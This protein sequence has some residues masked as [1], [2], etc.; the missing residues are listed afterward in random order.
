[1]RKRHPGNVFN[2]LESRLVEFFRFVEERC[3]STMIPHVEFYIFEVTMH[4]F[5]Q[6][7]TKDMLVHSSMQDEERKFVLDREKGALV[8]SAGQSEQADLGVLSGNASHPSVLGQLRH[9]V[10][11]RNTRLDKI[12]GN[13]SPLAEVVRKE[14]GD[15]LNNPR[16]GDFSV[17]APPWESPCNNDTGD[18]IKALVAQNISGYDGYLV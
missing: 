4:E 3:V 7:F 2:P 18:G 12:F 11:I 8:L 15:E 6:V 10:G 1:M 13:P 9:L 17:H 14:A 16:I 5:L